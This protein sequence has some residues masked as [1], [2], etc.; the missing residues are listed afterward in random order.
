TSAPT[1][2]ATDARVPLTVGPPLCAGC[3]SESWCDATPGEA[4]LVEKVFRK[5][6]NSS[7]VVLP[8][9]FLPLLFGKCR[10]RFLRDASQKPRSW[11]LMVRRR[12]CP[13]ALRPSGAFAPAGLGPELVPG[14]EVL[15]VL[16]TVSH[17]AVLE[18]EDDAVGNAR[19]GN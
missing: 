1:S 7:T 14:V 11:S 18:L 12:V 16:P 10:A 3:T 19:S 4:P 6:S 13:A 8:K 15:E 2:C 5:R 17:L 9:S